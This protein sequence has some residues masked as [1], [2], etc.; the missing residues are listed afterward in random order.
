[1][2]AIIGPM[3][4]LVHITASSRAEA[5][6]IA[7]TLVEEKLA[8][9]ANLIPGVTS[10]YTWEGKTCESEEVLL[11]VKTTRDRIDALIPRVKDLHSYD[12]P[13]IVAVPVEAGLPAYLDWVRDSTR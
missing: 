10:I 4:L 7:R 2:D 13:E 6:A 5:E 8:A 9:C 1:M 3:V 11:E 12:V